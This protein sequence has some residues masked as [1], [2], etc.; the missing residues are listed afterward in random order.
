MTP[1]RDR[2]HQDRRRDLHRQLGA[3]EGADR[4][5]AVPDGQ[6]AT[7]STRSCPRTTAWPAA[8]S[9]PSRPRVSRARSRCPAR[10]ATPPPSTAWRSAPRR[11]TS[12][13]TP[14]CS[15]RRPARPPSQLCNGTTVDKVTGTAPFTTPGNNN[16]ELDH[17][18]PAPDHEGQPQ[19]RHRRGLDHQG[20]A[21]PGRRRRNGAAGLQVTSLRTSKLMRPAPRSAAA[22]GAFHSSWS[23]SE[24]RTM[25][26][27][28]RGPATVST[29]A[30][31]TVRQI[32]AS[33][34]PRSTH[35]CSA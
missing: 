21:L 32:D 8:S 19:R 18:R 7:R 14:V 10:T 26:E 2:R 20:R 22:Q 1:R 25:A 23:S 28:S 9:P 29:S 31:A 17:H 3:G 24:A 12:G 6:P 5:G 35:A 15:A 30:T 27:A 11:S 16:V 33:R 34:P 4:D 13:R